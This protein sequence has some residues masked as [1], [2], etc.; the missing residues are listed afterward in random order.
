[1]R[2]QMLWVIWQRI[3][4]DKLDIECPV[5]ETV[6]HPD[7]TTELILDGVSLKFTDKH[8]GERMA[9]IF[10]QAANTLCRGQKQDKLESLK[11]NVRSMREAA[12]RLEEMLDPLELVSCILSTRCDLCPVP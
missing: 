3:L 12:E 10:N 8:L 4:H 7:G 6:S 9:K 5:V 1:M 2:E 11:G